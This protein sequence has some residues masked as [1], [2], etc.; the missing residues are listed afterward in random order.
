MLKDFIKEQLGDTKY[1]YCHESFLQGYDL[2]S[3]LV[4]QYESIYEN[5]PEPLQGPE[6]YIYNPNR[7]INEEE[8]IDVF[9]STS[10]NDWDY[11]FIYHIEILE[12]TFLYRKSSVLKFQDQWESWDKS[13]FPENYRWYY[14]YYC[15]DMYISIELKEEDVRDLDFMYYQDYF[16]CFI[17][18]VEDEP[19]DLNNFWEDYEN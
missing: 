9:S 18:F 3:D 7:I 16:D 8:Q 6:V 14:Y 12:N 4:D 2:I 15:L 10:K 11:N 5:D 13:I 19:N 17:P 1:E